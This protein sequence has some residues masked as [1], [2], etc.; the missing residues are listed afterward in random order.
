MAELAQSIDL[1]PSLNGCSGC[2]SP[3][4]CARDGFCVFPSLLRSVGTETRLS[5]ETA[6]NLLVIGL[7]G[8]QLKPRKK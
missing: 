6:H 1:D 8:F 5:H 3:A 2:I 4:E 7:R